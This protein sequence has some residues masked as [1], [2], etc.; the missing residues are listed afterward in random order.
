MTESG[1]S[2]VL[3]LDAKPAPINIE[4]SKTALLVVD[5]QNDFGSKGGMFDRAGL[6]ISMIQATVQP[7]LKVLVAARNTG[8]PIVYLKMGFSPDL[9]DLGTVDSPNRMRHLRFG[10]GQRISAP[11]GTEGRML[12]RDTWNTD[13]VPELEPESGDIVIYKNRFSGFFE[14]ELDDVLRRRGTKYLIVTGCTTSVCVEST[15]RDAMFRDYSCVLLED[16]MGEPIG[17]DLPRSNHEA[18]LL[19]IQT[20]F[21]WVSKSTDVLKCLATTGVSMPAKQIAAKY[22]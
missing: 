18:S 13:I 22:P 8:I 14:T 3:I 7:T 1:N 21:G 19:T 5:M 6:D 10:V 20:L 17:N 2:D 15:V 16:C 9:S 11:D 12:I 4:T